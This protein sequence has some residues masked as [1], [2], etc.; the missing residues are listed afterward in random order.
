MKAI[1]MPCAKKTGS[2]WTQC[3][4]H[5]Q[6]RKDHYESNADAMYKNRKD[7]YESNSD[8][9]CHQKK[10]QY[11]RNLLIIMRKD[12]L[13]MLKM[14]GLFPRGW[15][16]KLVG[17][18][19]LISML[20]VSSTRQE[21]IMKE[22]IA[23]TDVTTCPLR[24]IEG[25]LL[26]RPEKTYQMSLTCCIWKECWRNSGRRFVYLLLL[27]ETL[28]GTGL[29]MHCLWLSYHWIGRSEIHW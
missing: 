11:Y 12:K 5:M 15:C 21:E 6:K 22:M 26:Q 20:P 27:M 8:V 2:L 17:K 28:T 10:I 4:C 9:I 19:L 7:H 3:W 29:S 25:R 18:V 23:I 16:I 24:A 13:I 14:L 1:L